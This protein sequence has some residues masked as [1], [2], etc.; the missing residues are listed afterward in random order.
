PQDS[1][2]PPP[3]P[4]PLLLAPGGR[5][6]K[7]ELR[8]QLGMGT[9]GLVFTARDTDLD[10][11]VALKVLNP[12]HVAN[13]DVVQRFLQEAR[14]SARIHHPGIVTVFDFGRV[15]ASTGETAFIA[16]ELLGGESLTSRLQ[17]SG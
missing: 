2:T 12:T 9:F 8:E 11:D 13:R 3:E 14:A 17:R 10:R 15:P 16:M 1:V 7:Y 5:V 6:G 4:G